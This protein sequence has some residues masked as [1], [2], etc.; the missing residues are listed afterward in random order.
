MVEMDE[1]NP[2]FKKLA[3]TCPGPKNAFAPLK[4]QSFRSSACS[5]AHT[6]EDSVFG[7]ENGRG[8]TLAHQQGCMIPILACTCTCMWSGSLGTRHCRGGLGIRLGM[9]V[10]VRA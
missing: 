7:E 5:G 10:H 1:D 6:E 4:R 9:I 3:F 2:E 8:C